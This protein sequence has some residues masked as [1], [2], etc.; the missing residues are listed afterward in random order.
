MKKLISISVILISILTSCKKDIGVKALTNE[1]I[2]SVNYPTTKATETSFE[3][4]DI[5]GAYI[6]EYEDDKPSILQLGGNYI[7]NA[8]VKNLGTSWAATPAI[9]WGD[10]K[11]D[12]YAYYPYT[13]PSSIDEMTFDVATDQRIEGD[14]D[15]LDA[16][17]S[18]DFLYATTKSVTSDE[19]TVKLLFK[20]IMS[21]LTINFVKGEDFEGEIPEDATVVIHNV[22]PSAI[23]DLSTGDVVKDPHK[24]AQSIFAKK[25][26]SGKY[27]AIIVP[28]TLDNAAPLVEVIF[29]DISYL[30]TSKFQFKSGNH[31]SIN[32]I[33]TDN[34]EKVKIE[35][36]GEIVTW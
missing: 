11:Y 1:M 21:K 14:N 29:N 13:Q 2:F 20:H 3:T 18:S 12:V 34:P 30:F 25:I 6:T 23:I 28:Q 33:M 7:N 4:G 36:G 16:Y 32:I 26:K 22:I 24:S 19:Q 8:P 35:I 5:F 9:Y 15:T 17:E 27:S 31:H 10:G